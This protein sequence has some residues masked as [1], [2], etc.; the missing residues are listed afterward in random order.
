MTWYV[1]HPTRINVFFHEFPT[2]LAADLF[3]Q[4]WMLDEYVVVT[5]AE[6]RA[7]VG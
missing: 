6:L 1:V 2:R 3:R 5:G 7:L 4:E